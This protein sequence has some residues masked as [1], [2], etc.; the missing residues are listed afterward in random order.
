[1]LTI[2]TLK[3]KKPVDVKFAR[4]WRAPVT[5][6]RASQDLRRSSG[7]VHHQPSPIEETHSSSKKFFSLKTENLRS[8]L[9]FHKWS[10]ASCFS[11]A[12]PHNGGSSRTIWKVRLGRTSLKLLYGN[13]RL[14]SRIFCFCS[15]KISHS[16]FN[17]E[18]KEKTKLRVIYEPESF[19]IISPRNLL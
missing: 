7:S 13:F 4:P 9:T 11:L 18:S 16:F 8:T 17:E 19:T 2:W 12:F 3:L 5:G 14:Q 15:L 10:V 6:Q 1:M